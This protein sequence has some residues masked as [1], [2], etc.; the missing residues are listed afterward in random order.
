MESV[1]RAMYGTSHTWLTELV[2]GDGL[3]VLP[4]RSNPSRLACLLRIDSAVAGRRIKIAGKLARR[5]SLTGE[6]LDALL[7]VT[8]RAQCEGH[9]DAAHVRVIEKFLDTLPAGIDHESLV[10]SE[11][12]LVDLAKQVSPEQLTVAAH[13]LTALLDP[14]GELRDKKDIARKCFVRLGPQEV[15]GTS[16]MAGVIDAEFRAYLEPVLA[17]LARKGVLNPDEPKPVHDTDL[18]TA[19]PGTTPDSTDSADSADGD[20]R[21]EPNPDGDGADEQDCDAMSFGTAGSGDPGAGTAAAG[22][23]TAS[24]GSGT[25]STGSPGPL[26]LF[27][28]EETAAGA[29]LEA[30]AG[31]DLRTQGQ[32]N[33]DAVKAVF[34]QTLAA[35]TLGTHRGLPVTAVV[36]MSASDL[37]TA[38]G[39]AV[40]GTGSLVSIR[41]AIRMA[42]HAHHYLAVFDDDGRALYLGRGKRLASAD[43]RIVLIAR[44]RG[45]S[46]PNC[47][48]PATWSQV[49]HIDEWAD[50]GNTDIDD[51]TFGCDCHHP[52]VGDGPNQW[53]TTTTGPDHPQPGRTAW[54]P[55]ESVDP[56]RNGLVNHLNHNLMRTLDSPNDQPECPAARRCL[57]AH[58]LR[59]D[60]QE[61]RCPA[62]R[63]RLQGAR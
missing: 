22:S 11:I 54:H 47:T 18:S 45:C 46:F 25:A 57:R 48:R 6:Q 15:D 40:T 31:R 23:G 10:Q 8:A 26:T 1:S 17:K 21:N 24:A 62:S 42:A 5:R 3:A 36:S 44:D 53:A 43:Q 32:R 29:E 41:D 35:G 4:E 33:H 38:S 61:S 12:L 37:A 49:H 59:P 56:R 58:L 27:G 16:K 13:R 19:Y 30:R 60:R 51:L 34:R 7:P 55:P 2:D 14:D 9:L 28:P 39:H 52:L 20:G 63:G 50:G